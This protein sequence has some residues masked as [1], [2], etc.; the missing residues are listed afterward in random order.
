MGVLEEIIR[1]VADCEAYQLEGES[2]YRKEQE[3]VICYNR[4]AELLKDE[5]LVKVEGME[6]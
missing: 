4:I 1:I 3:K 2:E 5:K 6:C